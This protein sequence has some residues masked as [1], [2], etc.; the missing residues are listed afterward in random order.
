[1]KRNALGTNEAIRTKFAAQITRNTTT[2]I[3][4]VRD[5]SAPIG[6]GT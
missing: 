1:M 3:V 5:P 6:K 2:E 4:G